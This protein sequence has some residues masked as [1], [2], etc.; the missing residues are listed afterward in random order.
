MNKHST[1]LK[2]FNIFLLALGLIAAFTLSG[3]NNDTASSESQQQ[4]NSNE[5]AAINSPGNDSKTEASKQLAQEFDK[6]VKQSGK[7][8]QA[9]QFIRDHIVEL[10]NEDVSH[11]LLTLEDAQIQQLAG[12]VD[13]YYEGNYQEQLT[14]AYKMDDTLDDLIG[15]VSDSALKSLLTETRDSGYMLSTVEGMFSPDMDYTKAAEFTEK[16]TEDTKA[17]FELRGEESKQAALNDAALV[18]SWEELLKRALAAEQFTVKYPDAIRIQEVHS[19]RDHYLTTILFGANNTPL[20]DY[21]NKIMKPEARA[22][23]EAALDNAGEYADSTIMKNLSTFMAA[24]GKENYKLTE[25]LEKVR[26]QLQ[27]ESEPE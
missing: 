14:S 25:A 23:Y 22:A 4:P 9:I 17:Y 6:L 12:L 21:D 2:P 26:E 11:V 19:L 27:P 18:I 13:R 16:A 1:I 3:C 10:T 24:A 7:L 5:S 8:P 15:K 20:F